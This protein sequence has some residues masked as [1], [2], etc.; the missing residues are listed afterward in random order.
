MILLLVHH[1]DAVVSAVDSTRPLSAHGRAQ[2]SDVATRV[3]AHDIKPVAIWHSGKLRARETAE[4]YWRAVNPA[5]SFTAVKGLQPDD[6]PE[7]M[8]DLLAEETD[9][10]MIVSHYPF[11]PGLLQGLT[12]DNAVFPQHGTIA[13]ERTGGAWVEKWKETVE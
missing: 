9:D 4:I 1:A 3:A 10:L 11:L 8:M 2:A 13:L 6:D 12:G 5:A 7:W